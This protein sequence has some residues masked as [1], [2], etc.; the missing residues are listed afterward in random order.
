MYRGRQRPHPPFVQSGPLIMHLVAE[1]LTVQRGGRAVLDGV[2]L[3]VAG[4]EALL[5]LGANGAG[6]T[7][8][9]RTLAGLIRPLSGRVRIDGAVAE[10]SVGEQCHFVGHTNAIKPSLTTAENIEFWGAYLGSVEP[11]RAPDA[12][13]DPA[14]DWALE[15]LGLGDL[16]DV[17]AG[18]L[19]AG[20]KRRLGL[21][22]LLVARRPIWLLDEPTVSLDAAS[23]A[24]FAGIVAE[25]LA[26]GGIVVAATHV[27]LGLTGAHELR[28]GARTVTV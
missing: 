6:K 4:G 19:S 16:R 1:N 26:G 11:E 9:L 18:Y 24:L 28:L 15:R 8:L 14:L 13:P 23:V 20:Q 21:A 3:R 27:P 22:R 10:Q 25:H 12:K 17:P 5:L 2:S 7:T